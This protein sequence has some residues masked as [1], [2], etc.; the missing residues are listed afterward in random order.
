[1]K[2]VLK[3][4]PFLSILKFI[5]INRAAG[6]GRCK[7]PGGPAELFEPADKDPDPPGAKTQGGLILKLKK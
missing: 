1:M 3:R 6:Q 2:F 7:E 5:D 4:R